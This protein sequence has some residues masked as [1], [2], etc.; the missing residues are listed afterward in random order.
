MIATIER[1]P[2]PPQS[3]RRTELR[4][5]RVCG[6]DSDVRAA[7]DSLTA[8]AAG[9]PVA[10]AGSFMPDPGVR[11][12][13]AALGIH[14]G[15]AE[16]DFFRYRH[17][18]TP[19]AGIAPRDRKVWTE[20]EHPLTDLSSPQVRRAQVALGLLRMEGAQP[21][22][23]GRHDDP[24]TLALAASSPGTKVIEDTT[25]T[26]RLHFAP[27]FGVVC[28]TTL[29]P[30]RVA[31]LLAQLRM[32]Y[33]D[34]KVTYLNTSAPSMTQREQALEPLLDWCDTVLV[35]GQP[36]EATCDALTEAAHRKGKPHLALP[37]PA[38]FEPG[39]LAGA[40][41]IAL[42]AGGFATDAAIRAIHQAVTATSRISTS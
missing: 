38:A 31:W 4:I 41:R 12:R 1:T 25:D 8:L 9:A 6:M 22:V 27:A 19:Y 5:A 17:V 26:A 15:V 21:L 33:R 40:R 24:E 36:G 16:P 10:V 30:R 7:L 28:Q 35:V 14:E 39:L 32:R 3:V 13:L 34:A 20:A 18:V 37:D 42:T 23:I 11:E 2:N 29:S